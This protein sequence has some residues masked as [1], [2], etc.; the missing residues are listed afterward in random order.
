MA[1]G[2]ETE[3]RYSVLAV[4]ERWQREWAEASVY[5]AKDGLAPKFY[6]L[7]MFPYPSGHLHMGHVRVYTIGDLLARFHR[8]NGFNVLHPMGWDAFGLPAENAAIKAGGHPDAYTRAN[9]AHMK[10]QMERLGL[11]FDWTREVATCDLEYYRF[12]QELFLLLYERGL[13]YRRAAAVNWCPSC[14]TVLANEQV[15]D[16][17]CWRCESE[18]VKKELVQWFFRITQYADRLLGD[19]DRLDWP[20]FITTQQRHW[21]G[22][23]E[24]AHITFP[25]SGHPEGIS[26]FTTRPDTLFGA[27]YVVLAPEH[28]LVEALTRGKPEAAGVRQFAHEQRQLS[29]QVRTAEGTEKRGVFTGAVAQHP[30]TGQ[31]VPIWVA[32]YVL[33]DYGTGAVMG[34]PAHDERDFQF[35]RQYG[36]PVVR[37]VE[38][39]HPD[40]EVVTE[41]YVGPGRLVNSGAFD[42]MPSE[43]AK[44]AIGEALATKNLGGGQVTYRMRDWLISRQRYWGAPI[45]MI[46]CPVC[47]TV[48]VPKADLPV[49]LP[50]DVVF[51]GTGQSPLA[52]ATDWVET[53]CPMCGGP[54]RRDTDTMDTFIDSSWYFLRYT[55][56]HDRQQMF[57]PTAAQFWMPVDLYVGGKEH[58]VLHLL[59]S[60][61]ITKVL[62]DA[63]LVPADEPFSRLLSQGMVVHGGAKMSKSKGNVVSPED[64]IAAF[65]ADACRLFMLFAAP[66]EKDLEWSDQGVEGAYRFLQRVFRLVAGGVS[67]GQ[68]TGPADDRVERAVA[69]TVKKVTEDVGDRRS[70]NTAVA[71]LMELT[72]VMTAHQAEAG[73]PTMDAARRTLTRLLAPFAPFLAEE[74][75]HRL[76]ALSSVHEEVWPTYDPALLVEATVEVAVQ[77]N[78]K[79]RVRLMVDASLDAE[80]LKNL[81]LSD[82]K[83]Q[84][85][86]SGRRVV[87]AVAIPGRLV[88]L[89]VA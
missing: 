31:D 49:K 53:V 42:G 29:E 77:V 48:P 56:P 47:G 6:C 33:G 30:L 21:I 83:V 70:F 84:E 4:E 67:N 34:V 66:Y 76:G 37:V 32:N 52:A 54:A 28:P 87:K 61:F 40:Q 36:L 58:A 57:D 86:L 16:G 69:R 11:S 80:A 41:A 13:A 2:V 60:R 14:Q 72:N 12:T 68:P 75:W 50:S 89:V 81:V 44:T 8:M 23:S 73:A 20:S 59:Y 55:S 22:R 26:V 78:G 3:D 46:H 9:I 64:I 63:G 7:E 85:A 62:H 88:N 74:L 82:V 17:L 38:G 51:S 35:A 79:V 71:A 24:G 19:L 43:A 65:G 10:Q 39:P 25:V 45:P 5:Q 1:T 18:V 27:T 15:E